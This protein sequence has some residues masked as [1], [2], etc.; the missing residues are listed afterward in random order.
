MT[1]NNGKNSSLSAVSLDGRQG[2]TEADMP[3][4]RRIEH[5]EQEIDEMN[6]ELEKLGVPMQ[7][8]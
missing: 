3:P 8:A 1:K 2:E 6:R 5:L 4:L 7:S